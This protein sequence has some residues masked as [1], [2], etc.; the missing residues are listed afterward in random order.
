M[1]MKLEQKKL[2]YKNRFLN[3]KGFYSIPIIDENKIAA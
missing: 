2:L 3:L 1:K